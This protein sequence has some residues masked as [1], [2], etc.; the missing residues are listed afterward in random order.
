MT[1]SIS[2]KDDQQQ[3][4]LRSVYNRLAAFISPAPTLRRIDGRSTTTYRSNPDP[5]SLHLPHGR[6]PQSLPRSGNEPVARI[7]WT[8]HATPPSSVQT[9]STPTPLR[10]ASNN[11]IRAFTRDI[12]RNLD[13]H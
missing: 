5:P 3:G 2:D 4:A 9:S 10:T 6:S 12:Q 11:N 13:G 1:S 8:E 7:E